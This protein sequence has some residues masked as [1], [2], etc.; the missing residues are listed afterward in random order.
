MTG[1]QTCALPIY[2]FGF[3]GAALATD[4]I[5]SGAGRVDPTQIGTYLGNI[6]PLL[7]IDGNGQVD[8][9]TDGLLIV[10]Y[11]LGLHG[12]TLTTGAIGFSATRTAATDIETYLQS[13]KP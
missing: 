9:L 11:L 10:R 1:V 8:A 12:A 13:L 5:G 2:L 3:S 4:A 7:D 6:R